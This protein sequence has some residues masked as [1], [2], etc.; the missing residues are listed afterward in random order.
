MREEREGDGECD[1]EF[2]WRGGQKLPGRLFMVVVTETQSSGEE[3]VLLIWE[4][5]KIQEAE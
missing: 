1:R 4:E 5:E 3:G 2:L